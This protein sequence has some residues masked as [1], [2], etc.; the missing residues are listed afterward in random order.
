MLCVW[1][2]VLTGAL[3]QQATEKGSSIEDPFSSL[4]IGRYV[5][6]TCICYTSKLLI[7][8]PPYM[9]QLEKGGGLQNDFRSGHV[10]SKRRYGDGV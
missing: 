1:V 9:V 2:V 7:Q 8:R 10:A 5:N 3:I 4:I 6:L